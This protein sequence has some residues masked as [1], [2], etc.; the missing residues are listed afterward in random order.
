MGLK[1]AKEVLRGQRANHVNKN[2]FIWNGNNFFH[3][4]DLTRFYRM[5]IKTIDIDIYRQ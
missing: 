3:R 1:T 2:K 4:K 5:E